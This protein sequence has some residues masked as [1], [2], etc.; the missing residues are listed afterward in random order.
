VAAWRGQSLQTSEIL[1]PQRRSQPTQ[2]NLNW[3]WENF[4]SADQGW[5]KELDISLN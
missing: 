3:I 1:L 5:K 2:A 4:S